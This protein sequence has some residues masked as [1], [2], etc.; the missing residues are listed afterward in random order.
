MDETVITSLLKGSPGFVIAGIIL[1]LYVRKVADYKELVAGRFKDSEA[2]VS[3]VVTLV[4][5]TVT[6]DQ[7]HRATIEESTKALQGMDRR[8]EELIAEVRR[9]PKSEEPHRRHP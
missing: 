3:Q 2:A 9:L 1:W 7:Q 4:R 6:S 8:L 5:E